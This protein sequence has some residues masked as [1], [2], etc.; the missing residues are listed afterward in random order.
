MI[1]LND[2]IPL[3]FSNVKIRFNKKFGTNRPAIDYFTDQTEESKNVMLEG[4]YW[5]FNKKKNF[6]VGNIAIGFVPIPSKQ[7][8]WLLFHIGEVTEDLNI[9]NGIGYRHKI[10]SLYDKF[11]G[12]LIV[13]YHNKG[14]NMVR[15]GDKILKECEVVEI[16]P[17]VYNN[18]FFPG[19]FNVNVSW[20]TLKNLIT[21]PSWVTALKNQKG[22]YLLVDTSNGKKYVGSAYG[23]NMILGRWECYIR[24]G[25]GGNEGLKE[26]VNKKGVQHIQDNFYFTILDVFNENV[27]DQMIIDRE[28]YWKEVL[29]TRK[30]GYNK[31]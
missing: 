17:N 19:Y 8:H 25:H 10:L 9:Q 30:H 20:Q 15:K 16:L 31:N 13:K 1:R 2:L 7:D 28:T 18:D 6:V 21:K 3:D 26:L 14:R 24:S 22:V 4:M 23:G 11:I 12:R 5:N 29:L 27:P